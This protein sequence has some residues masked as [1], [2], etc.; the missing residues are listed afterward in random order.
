MKSASKLQDIREQI[1]QARQRVYEL[2]EQYQEQLI[3]ERLKPEQRET[4]DMMLRGY[5]RDYGAVSYQYWL[6]AVIRSMRANI[7]ELH[8]VLVHELQPR[9]ASDA[10]KIKYLQV[11][12]RQMRV[13]VKIEMVNSAVTP[14]KLKKT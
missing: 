6:R 2:G 9:T 4:L 14:A 3:Y 10:Q 11:M 5:Q 12:A 1:E 13:S 8:Q 7:N